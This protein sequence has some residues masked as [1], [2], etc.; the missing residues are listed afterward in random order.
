MVR[1]PG[2][3]PVIV[4]VASFVCTS[5][6]HTQ[7][8]TGGKT[9]PNT[10]SYS[11]V[12][13]LWTV[14]DVEPQ[15]VLKAHKCD[16]YE[17]VILEV[18]MLSLSKDPMAKQKREELKRTIDDLYIFNTCYEKALAIIE[19]KEIELE[20]SDETGTGNSTRE[21][22]LFLL[23]GLIREILAKKFGD[24]D[25]GVWVSRR[26]DDDDRQ[27]NKNRRWDDDDCF[28]YE[29]ICRECKPNR[30]GSCCRDWCEDMCDGQDWDLESERFCNRRRCH[31]L[32]RKF[33][34]CCSSRCYNW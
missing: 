27:W 10:F 21:G 14:L 20:I 5:N 7:S 2:S 12:G 31:P 26:W 22:R 33:E 25:D 23:A 28:C 4:L 19:K 3:L 1:G 16:K 6:V 17:E 15:E 11:G 30:E 32:C 24:D 9:Q 29:D 34:Y 8:M 13:E 18:V